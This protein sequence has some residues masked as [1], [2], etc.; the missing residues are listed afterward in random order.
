[1]IDYMITCDIYVLKLFS[2]GQWWIWQ[3][4][5]SVFCHTVEMHAIGREGF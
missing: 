5:P 2:V 3:S 4:K 1:M